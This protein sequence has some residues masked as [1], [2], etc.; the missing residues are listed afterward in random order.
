MCRTDR[1][2][3]KITNRTTSLLEAGGQNISRGKFLLPNSQ[4]FGKS[5]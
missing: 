1:L 5:L 3:V 2:N 4:S